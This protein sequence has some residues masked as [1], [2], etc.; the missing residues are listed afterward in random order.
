MP[1]KG[2]WSFVPKAAASRGGTP[3]PQDMYL[4]FDYLSWDHCRSIRL[5]SLGGKRSTLRGKNVFLP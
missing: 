1:G 4:G 2:S 5:L 3:G